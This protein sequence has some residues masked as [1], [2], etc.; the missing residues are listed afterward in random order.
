MVSQRILQS[1]TC[2]VPG[3]GMFLQLGNAVMLLNCNHYNL[4]SGFPLDACVL[5]LP[6]YRE[7][8]G[9]TARPSGRA[10]YV[11]APR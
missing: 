8:C 4:D 9:R 10:L 6:A 7:H 5:S 1:L 3:F 2:R 11:G